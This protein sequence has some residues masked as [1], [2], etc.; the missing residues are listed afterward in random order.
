MKKFDEYNLILEFHNSAKIKEIIKNI[1]DNPEE[2]E[3]LLDKLKKGELSK[4]LQEKG[5][6][7]TFGFLK[8]IFEEA[9]KFQ[10]KRDVKKGGVKMVHRLIPIITG[11]ISQFIEFI[12][13]ILGG[14]RAFNKLLK[15]IIKDPGNNY[16]EFLK[17]W[18]MGFMNIME[19]DYYKPILGKNRFY[20][21]FV[22]SDKTAFM[23]DKSYLR[24]FSYYLAEKMS[25]ENDKK[26]VPHYYIE[27][28]LKNWLNNKFEIE[29]KIQ[30]KP[31]HIPDSE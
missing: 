19:G 9:I 1:A 26:E 4:Y 12:S 11:G 25:Y 17:K 5:D 22:I 13:Y 18:I 15:P 27:N 7:F 30:F 29:P 8:I 2:E 21:A 14:S 3:I 28:E 16:P 6:K 20:K 10:K 24:E 31:G 23:L